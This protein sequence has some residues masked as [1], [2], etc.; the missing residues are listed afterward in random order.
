MGETRQICEKEFQTFMQTPCSGGGKQLP[1]LRELCRVISF[2]LLPKN[3]K[4]QED[5]FVVETWQARPQ[6]GDEG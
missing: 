3:Q 6:S 4:E 5:D 2:Q 1:F